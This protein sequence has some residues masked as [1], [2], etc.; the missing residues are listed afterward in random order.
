MVPRPLLAATKT[1]KE[2]DRPGVYLLTGPTETGGLPTVYIGEGSPV[3]SRLESHLNA[4]D[5]W[6]ACVFFTANDESLNKA[7]IQHLESRLIEL[8]Q[9]A[10]RCVLD[11][12]QQP[13][14]PVLSESERADSENFLAEILSI[15]PL[16]GVSVCEQP[17]TARPGLASRTPPPL[18]HLQ[19]RQRHGPRKQCRLRR[20]C[21]LRS[22]PHVQTHALLPG[23]GGQPPR[24]PA[25]K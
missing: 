18:S 19:G 22:R 16:I 9:N 5:F 13:T 21:R 6:T 25:Q 14:P 24:I 4:K 2:F 1:R 15:L 8:A 17:V 7:H 10:K 3:R 23:T 20:A 11:N 12:A